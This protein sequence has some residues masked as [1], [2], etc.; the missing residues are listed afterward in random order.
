[1][2]VAPAGRLGIHG[3]DR[4]LRPAR[5]PFI[6]S[7]VPKACRVNI[8]RSSQSPYLRCFAKCRFRRNFSPAGSS[9][10]IPNPTPAIL[11]EPKNTGFGGTAL[12]QRGFEDLVRPSANGQSNVGL[13]PLIRLCFSPSAT[14]ARKR[15][16]PQRPW[17]QPPGFS[18]F[19]PMDRHPCEFRS[20]GEQ[21][22]H[23]M[24]N[25]PS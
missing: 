21:P 19:H 14:S 15:Q 24:E 10:N 16:S 25:F 18:I 22:S 4:I 3:T 9:E 20:C 2:D 7:A 6:P 5:T 11:G 17:T 12:Q 13:P 23:R 8:Q 1:L